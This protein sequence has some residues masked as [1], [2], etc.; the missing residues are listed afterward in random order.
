MSQL[1]TSSLSEKELIEKAQS[2]EQ[3]AFTELM[4]RY[5]DSVF[6]IILKIV[7]NEED[8]ADLVIIT[9]SKAFLN[10]SRYVETHSFATW[11]FTIASNAS[12]DWLRK[13]KLK[14]VGL[15]QTRSQDDDEPI[16]YQFT[17][18][19]QSDLPDNPIIKQQ[20]EQAVRELLKHLTPELERVMTHR[21]LKEMSYDE[22]AKELNLPL[23]TVKVQIHRAKK[24]LYEKLRHQPP[25]W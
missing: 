2:G 11:L 1:D 21:F 8:A 6:H 24:L 19:L 7:R 12:I 20:R 10:I 18:G 5:K 14:T 23:G 25:P 17:S 9:F 15:D 22:I 16:I 13:R 3:R 4:N